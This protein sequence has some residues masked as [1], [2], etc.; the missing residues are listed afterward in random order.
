MADTITPNLAL[1]KP[2]I[3]ASA[4]S[5]GNKLNG[6]FDILDLK[7][8]RQTI[9]WTL[10]LGD[11]NPA[12]GAGAFL[13]ER[14]NNAGVKSGTPV[15]INRQT[16]DVALANNL[17]VNGNI[18]TNALSCTSFTTNGNAI[19]AGAITAT[20]LNATN[21]ITTPGYSGANMALTGAISSNTVN[22]NAIT[23]GALTASGTTTH[24]GAVQN[25]GLV[26]TYSGG[27]LG[28]ASRGRTEFTADASGWAFV[29][30]H[31]PASF[32]SNFGM[33]PNGHFYK[34]GGSNGAGILYK[35]HTTQDFNYT[36]PSTATVQSW[37]NVLISD[38]VNRD[39]NLF[40]DYVA[41]I[42]TAENNRANGDTSLFNDYNNKLNDKISD[43]RL[44]YA[45]DHFRT[46]GS[47]MN[48]PIGGA[49]VT[50]LDIQAPTPHY[51]LRLRR[52][53]LYKPNTGWF[54][55]GA[56]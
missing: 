50:G 3:G 6:N 53:Q 48:E 16:G 45:G 52:M 49:V 4:D 46:Q 55:V 36:P 32:I 27:D 37:D 33:H 54:T 41:R 12:S 14:W 9:Q 19:T 34:G 5:W 56:P 7:S 18:F 35:F 28:Q 26:T 24:N 2:E 38:Y 44:E 10:V 13:I 1:I 25:N 47:G 31:S 40:N 51:Q 21:S 29:S 20:T 42:S 8:V 39:T 15:T 11:D 23:T 43:G 30:F 22:T 17:T